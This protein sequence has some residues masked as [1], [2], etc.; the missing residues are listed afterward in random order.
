MIKSFFLEHKKICIIALCVIALLAVSVCVF[1]IIHNTNNKVE[2]ITV[3]SR[4]NLFSLTLSTKL[5]Y[6]VN[7]S[8]DNFSLDLCDSLNEVYIYGNTIEKSREI[9]LYDVINEDKNS[10][11]ASKENAFEVM[12]IKEINLDNCSGYEYSMT[13]KDSEYGKDFYCNIV[14]LQTDNHI[15]IINFEVPN[16]K[17]DNFK[18][19]FEDMKTSFKLLA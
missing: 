7:N 4:D 8:N 1:V 9:D 18:Q 17:V 12:G 19:I 11:F 13:Y 14:W 6:T 3:N 15:F 16:N 5:N 10:Y 2:F